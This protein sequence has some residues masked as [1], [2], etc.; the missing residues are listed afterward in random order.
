M[1]APNGQFI[2]EKF[3]VDR[4]GDDFDAATADHRR[5]GE[6]RGDK[7]K[8]MIPPD[9]IP[10]ISCGSNA[11]EGG[12]RAGP[13]ERAAWAIWPSTFAACSIPRSP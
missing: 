3:I 9:K 10:G 11:P 12:H 8:T 2:V 1:E 4:R 7:V 6:G 13:E 5:R